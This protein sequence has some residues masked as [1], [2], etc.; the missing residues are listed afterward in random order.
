[1]S[2]AERAWNEGWSVDTDKYNPA[3]DI[4]QA[5]IRRRNRRGQTSE[6]YRSGSDICGDLDLQAWDARLGVGVRRAGGEPELL[7]HSNTDQNGLSDQDPEAQDSDAE[8]DG[9]RLEYTN[10]D[11]YRDADRDKYRD[12]LTRLADAIFDA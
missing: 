5:E 10:A 11:A 1:M 2:A 8:S 6:D 4:I 12:G 9:Y 7:H 3:G